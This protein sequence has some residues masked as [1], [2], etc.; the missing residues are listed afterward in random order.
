VCQPA[1]RAVPYLNA[2]RSGLA[3]GTVCKAART[4]LRPD[5][6]TPFVSDSAKSSAQSLPLKLRAAVPRQ[7]FEVPQMSVVLALMVAAAALSP[8]ALAASC[9]T[10]PAA[11][12]GMRHFKLSVGKLLNSKTQVPER[13][14]GRA[15]PQPARVCRVPKPVTGAA[16]LAPAAPG[17][18]P[19]SAPAPPYHACP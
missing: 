6:H 2:R 4:P 18:G 9:P 14:P 17:A 16:L 19:P 7:A 8:Q 3:Y 1:K 15:G 13:A 12:P 10:L 11:P 5:R